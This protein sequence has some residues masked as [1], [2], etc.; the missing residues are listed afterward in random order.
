VLGIHQAASA[1]P[2]SDAWEQRLGGRWVDGLTYH[3]PLARGTVQID[4]RH[5]LAAGLSAFEVEDEFY[6]GLRLAEWVEPLAF[7]VR[8]GAVQP[9]AWIHDADSRRVAYCALGHDLRS[10]SAPGHTALLRR[11][12]DWLKEG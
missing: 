11:M 1:F 5:G 7:H 2:E 10:H 12:V 9:L 3:P 4:A 8:D 6:T